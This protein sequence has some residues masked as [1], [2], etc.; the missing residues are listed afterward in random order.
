VRDRFSRSFDNSRC[1]YCG[2]SRSRDRGDMNDRR[3]QCPT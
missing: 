3:P 1:G 2:P